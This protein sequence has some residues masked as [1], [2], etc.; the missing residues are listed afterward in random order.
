[1][2]TYSTTPEYAALVDAAE[3]WSAAYG[4]L[5]YCE[6]HGNARMIAAAELDESRAYAAWQLALADWEASAR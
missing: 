5:V 4:A 2:Y 6:A 1:M 3:A